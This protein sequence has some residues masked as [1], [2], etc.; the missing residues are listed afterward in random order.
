MDRIKVQQDN[1]RDLVFEGELVAEAS[2]SPNNACSN[3]SRETG[4]WCEL[5]LYRTAGGRYVCSQVGRTQWQGEH[6]R[7]EAA[8]VDDADGVIEFFGAGWLAKQLYEEASIECI[9]CVESA[10][11]QATLWEVEEHTGGR[12]GIGRGP[13]TGTYETETDAI[14][15]M[16]KAKAAG[17]GVTCIVRD[18]SG[19]GTMMMLGL[20]RLLDQSHINA[21]AEEDA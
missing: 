5:A 8:V 17:H 21:F 6:D 13:N 15:A 1:G 12:D 18:A 10:D 20:V 11:G 14:E 2:S 3:Y 7:H 9:E 16:A 19:R 4:R